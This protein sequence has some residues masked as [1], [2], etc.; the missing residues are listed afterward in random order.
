MFPTASVP[1]AA[2]PTMSKPDNSSIWTSIL[3]T[4]AVSSTTKARTDMHGSCTSPGTA[5]GPRGLRIE[6]AEARQHRD[7]EGRRSAR[8]LGGGGRGDLRSGR[9][10]RSRGGGERGGDRDVGGGDHR[11]RG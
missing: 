1:L 7:Q 9:R 3:R 4:W 10:G 5:P 8:R 6:G 2:W 11:A